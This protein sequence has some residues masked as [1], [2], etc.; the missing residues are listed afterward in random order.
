MDS[1]PNGRRSKKRSRKEMEASAMDKDKEETKGDFSLNA[2]QGTT[3]DQRVFKKRKLNFEDRNGPT[4]L[5]NNGMRPVA[6][7]KAKIR[8]G[9]RRFMTNESYSHSVLD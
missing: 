2:K 3:A 6:A 4:T 8:D 1:K 9:M 5:N 7:G